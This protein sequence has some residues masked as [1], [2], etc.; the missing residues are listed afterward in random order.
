MHVRADFFFP[1]IIDGELIITSLR[2]PHAMP[3]VRYRTGDAA[4]VVKDACSCDDSDPRIE[5]LGRINSDFVR[6]GGG[7]IRVEEVERI[8][9]PFYVYIEP[10]FKIEVQEHY[11][12]RK[13]T[14]ELTCLVIKKSNSSL[15]EEMLRY[16]IITVLMEELR[17]SPAMCLKDA[18]V[19]KLFMPPKVNFVSR[20]PFNTKNPRIIMKA[21]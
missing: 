4:H 12:K 1:E 3:L 13:R 6:I 18:V 19:A 8:M 20:L 11:S 7:E 21:N 15:S 9:T 17:L 16:Q 5:L 14:A 10:L 2:L